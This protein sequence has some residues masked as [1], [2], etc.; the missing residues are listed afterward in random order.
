M[1]ASSSSPGV[2]GTGGENRSASAMPSVAT[3]QTWLSE[4]ALGTT[5][6]QDAC[7]ANSTFR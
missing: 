1:T 6:N 2:S 7:G 3:C 4:L 5:R